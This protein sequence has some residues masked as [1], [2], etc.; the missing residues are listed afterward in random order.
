MTKDNQTENLVNKNFLEEL[1]K[2]VE[3]IE[4]DIPADASATL[5]KELLGRLPSEIEFWSA[6]SIEL[7]S[8]I[9]SV[10]TLIETKKELL[11]RE[12]SR[13][14]QEKLKLH[15]TELEEYF[16]TIKEIFKEVIES[17]NKVT[18]STLQEMVKAMRP[19]KPTKADLDDMANIETMD[20]QD[21][22][23]AL[24]ERKNNLE[25]YFDLLQ[26]RVKKYDNKLKSAI[27][28]K[29]ILVEE[30]KNQL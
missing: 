3:N 23:M 6:K 30:M 7:K 5:I 25:V 10:K 12:K 22:I 13:I 17:N 24:E 2:E 29:G 14:R 11:N 28:H 18:K 9:T 4:P 27:A 21:E 1:Q 26:A 15:K 20:L 16:K 8:Q 19:E